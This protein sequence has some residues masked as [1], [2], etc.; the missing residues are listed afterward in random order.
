MTFKDGIKFGFGLFVGV[1]LAKIVDKLL[2]AAINGT[3]N[4][5]KTTDTE[6]KINAEEA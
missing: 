1:K 6:A 4:D 2:G 3:T 5:N